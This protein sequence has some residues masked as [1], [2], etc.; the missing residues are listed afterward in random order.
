MLAKNS[1]AFV[2]LSCLVAVNA[3]ILSFEI[4]CDYGEHEILGNSRYTCT[5]DEI[6]YDFSTPFYFIR[7]VG[8]HD[9]GRSNN[10]VRNLRIRDSEINRIPANIFSVFPNIEG[11]EITNCGAINFIPPD[12]FFA[13]RLREVRIANNRMGRLFVSPFISATAIE[14][15][16]LEN[17]EIADLGPNPFVGLSRLHTLSLANNQIQ[18]ITARLMRPLGALRNFDASNNAIEEVDGRLFV[19]SPQ[20]EIVNLSGNSIRAVGNSILNI[21]ENLQQFWMAGNDCA[22]QNFVIGTNVNLETIRTGLSDCFANS[23]FGTQ[24]TLNVDGNLIIYDEN[25]QVL[26]RVN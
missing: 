2:L 11:L 1:L 16:V 17:N 26:L 13:D 23:P 10:D 19:N 12:F 25:D 9:T 6:D 4:E 20:V 21:N 3:Q 15:L 5:L 14:H 7:V 18:N 22:D 24:I 8:N